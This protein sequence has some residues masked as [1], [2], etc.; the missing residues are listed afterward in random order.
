MMNETKI[1][2]VKHLLSTGQRTSIS[3]KTFEE[4][5]ELLEHKT[6]LSIK[7]SK[8]LI[9]LR[10]ELQKNEQKNRKLLKDNE[11]LKVLT[12]H[13]RNTSITDS[14]DVERLSEEL[15]AKEKEIEQVKKFVASL[16]FNVDCTNW[17]ERFVVAFED[18]K[19]ELGNDRDNYKQALD[20]IEKYCNDILADRYHYSTGAVLMATKLTKDIINKAKEQ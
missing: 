9:R 17:F 16:M 11:E 18:W 5:I 3:T 6:Q 1:Q 2:E 13:W 7:Q 8:E 19:T 20:E 10:K 15:Q 4:I 12:K 14:Q